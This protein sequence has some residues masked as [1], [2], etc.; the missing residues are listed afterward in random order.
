M[1]QIKAEVQ[2]YIDVLIEM[3]TLIV[4]F[5]AIEHSGNL[6]DAIADALLK[7]ILHQRE[8]NQFSYYHQSR[9]EEL[10]WCLVRLF[11]RL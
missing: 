9:A 2:K 6:E 4:I 3:N 7:R 11:G 10:K 1:E 8:C 5:D